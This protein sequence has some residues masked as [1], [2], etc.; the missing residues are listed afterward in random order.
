MAVRWYVLRTVSRAEYLAAG[1][2]EHDGF[3]VYFPRVTSPQT[4]A[5]H[6]DT[7]LFPGYLFLRCD[8]DR[9]GWPSFRRAHR[10][11]GWVRFGDQVP[12]MPDEVVAEMIDRSG[13]INRT[14]GIWRRFKPGEKVRVVSDT[15][16]SL[17]EVAEEAKSPRARVRVLMKFMGRLVSA[18]VPWEDLRSIEEQSP[19]P[20][21]PSRRTRG[22]GRWVRGFGTRAVA[23]A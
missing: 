6:S 13:A 12:W 23:G 21:R 2:L 5:G 9:E 20:L 16:E 1:E 17:A 19:E 11:L 22:K 3:D 4:R 18:Q 7:P 10:V 14:G 15:L 8:P